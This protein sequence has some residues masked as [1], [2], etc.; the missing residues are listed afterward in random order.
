MDHSCAELRALCC[1]GG[2]M[3]SPELA[4]VYS[5]YW[6]AANATGIEL[7]LES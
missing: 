7:Y 4:C 5:P 6:R 2:I 1:L 3:V